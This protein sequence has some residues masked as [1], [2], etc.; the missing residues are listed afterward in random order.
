LKRRTEYQ[1]LWSD[2]KLPEKFLDVKED[3]LIL[4][5]ITLQAY[6]Q[7]IDDK[8]NRAK[9]FVEITPNFVRVG[10]HCDLIDDETILKAI[11]MVSK[12]ESFE[13]G[14]KVEFGELVNIY[15]NKIQRKQRTH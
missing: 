6:L 11:R 12:L 15:E 3:E 8:Q 1:H 13:I 10:I 2:G 9:E 5:V 4:H 14:T 7:E